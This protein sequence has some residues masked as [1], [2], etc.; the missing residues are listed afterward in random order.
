MSNSHRLATWKFFSYP[1]SLGPNFDPPPHTHTHTHTLTQGRFCF[2]VFFFQN[3]MVSSLG[4]REGF[5]QKL[6]W[7]VQYFL[8]HF[9]NG[10]TQTDRHTHT[11]TQRQTQSK[12][13][14]P[15]KHRQGLHVITSTS[16]NVSFSQFSTY[17]YH[18]TKIRY[19]PSH[20]HTIKSGIKCMPVSVPGTCMA[21][22]GSL[23]NTLG[24]SCTN[25]WKGLEI[26]SC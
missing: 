12:K 3:L 18:W 19:P 14:C 26:I 17:S 16:K 5:H 10:H 23:I 21:T 8:R 24:I 2:F 11:H 20:T 1:L 9:V 7:S 15:A 4:H 25:N 13:P 22:L 6:S